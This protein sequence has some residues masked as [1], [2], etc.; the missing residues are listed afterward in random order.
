MQKLYPSH[1]PIKAWAV[2]DRP[3]EKLINQGIENLAD[4][5][6]LAILLG[7]GTRDYSAIQLAY[8]VLE[9]SCGLPGLAISGV[10]EL[11][12]IKGIGPAK[13]LTMVVA[14]ELARR[15]EEKEIALSRN[16]LKSSHLTS[17]RLIPESAKLRITSSSVAASYLQT[18]ICD[19]PQEVFYVLFM[20]RNNEVISEKQI[21]AGG[22][23]TTIIDVKLVF[24]EAI[25]RL[26]SGVVVAHNHPSGN[27][28]PSQADIHITHKLYQ[29][30]KILDITLLDHVIITEYDHYSFADEGMLEG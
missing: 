14:F 9:E 15:K 11:S 21:F 10:E 28:Q 27:P 2:E 24:K 13:A 23:A 4:A 18:K 8:N 6:L 26:A 1:V 16:Q 22:V 29:A 5:E 12:K 20:N 30:S 7:T 25:G 3:R 19:L 17:R